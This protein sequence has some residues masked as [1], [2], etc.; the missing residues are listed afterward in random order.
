M[1]AWVGNVDPGQGN[2]LMADTWSYDTTTQ[3]WSELS[4]PTAPEK[5][6]SMVAGVDQQGGRDRFL[7]ALGEGEDKT[8]YNDVWALDLATDSWSKVC[9]V[10]L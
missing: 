8:F 10:H 1:R 6:F 2:G 7:I 3:T 4:T 5:R 9:A